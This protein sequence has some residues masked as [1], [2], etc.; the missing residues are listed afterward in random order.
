M[1]STLTHPR[2]QHPPSTVTS[3]LQ[4]RVVRRVGLLDRLALRVGLALVVW[5]R[6]PLTAPT[7]EERSRRLEQQLDRL[8]RERSYERTLLT[9]I[10]PR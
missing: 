4:Q 5:S 3:P 10:L 9:T 8:A 7:R 2:Q 1:N 6:R